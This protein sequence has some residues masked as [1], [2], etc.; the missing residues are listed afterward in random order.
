MKLKEA[1]TKAQMLRVGRGVGEWVQL[2]SVAVVCMRCGNSY[3]SLAAGMR[4]GIVRCNI[5]LPRS[6]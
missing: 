5:G 6:A 2:R 3:R 4:R 1:V